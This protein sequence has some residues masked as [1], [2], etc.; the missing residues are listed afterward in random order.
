MV[1]EIGGLSAQPSRTILSVGYDKGNFDDLVGHLMDFVAGEHSE[2][3][4]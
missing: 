3:S 2:D 1:A 4:R